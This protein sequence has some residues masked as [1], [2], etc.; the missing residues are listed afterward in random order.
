MTS[1]SGAPCFFFFFLPLGGAA[2]SFLDPRKFPR[3]DTSLVNFFLSDK[4]PPAPVC[5]RQIF[6]PCSLGVAPGD[7]PLFLRELLEVFLSPFLFPNMV[8]T[9]IVAEARPALVFP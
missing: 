3:R 5:L 4:D 9:Y 6:F 7:Y 1:P 8:D 2:F